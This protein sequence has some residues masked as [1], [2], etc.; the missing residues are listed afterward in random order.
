MVLHSLYT[1]LSNQIKLNL[2]SLKRWCS[3]R[4]IEHGSINWNTNKVSNLSVARMKDKS[5]TNLYA[6]KQRYLMSTQMERSK[7]AIQPPVLGNL[8]TVLSID[9][10]GVRGLIPAIILDFL[11][12]EL[13][14]PHASFDFS[15]FNS[16]FFLFCLNLYD[17]FAILQI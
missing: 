13:Q 5:L 15:I 11:E 12:T 9:G 7:S 16:F 3:S 10:G 6:H 1:N 14:V 2:R 8:I 4:K 17:I